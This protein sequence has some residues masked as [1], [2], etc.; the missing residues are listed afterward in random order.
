[1][2][3]VNRLAVCISAHAWNHN[4]TKV[5]LCPN[6]NEVKIYRKE[7][8]SFVLEETL[9]EHDSIVTAIDW[10]KKPNSRLLTCSQD[11]NAYV[12]SYE[13]STYKPTLVILRINRAATACQWSPKEDKFAVASGAKC[14]SVCYFETDNNWWVSKHIR[15]D[16]E[17][18]VTCID[19]H[20]NNILIAAGGTDNK[21][22]VVSG[23]VRGIDSRGDVGSTAFGSKLPFGTKCAEWPTNGWIQAI[24]WSP[25]GNQ[26]AWSSHD[27]AIHVLQCA[28]E[29]HQL[30]STRY[31]YLPFRDILWLDEKRIVGVGHD[32]N[33][34]LFSGAGTN[35]KIEKQLDV[36]GSAKAQDNSAKNMWQNR[37]KMGAADAGGDKQLDTK[38]QNCITV[39][40]Q[41]DNKSFSTSGLDGLLVVWPHSAVG[42]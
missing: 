40:R 14:L 19:W 15:A 3:S 17:S 42:L 21:A 12:W 24:K 4:H 41:V 16:I 28:N 30:A 35:W 8:N 27:S 6:N 7:G 1:V 20:P 11:R 18:T 25:S 37:A 31:A 13:N 32:A 29:S 36:G 26:L 38:H 22:R 34:V 2:A 5:A 23:F 39:I 9:K 33:P 10:G